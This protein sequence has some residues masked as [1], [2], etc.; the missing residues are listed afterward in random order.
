MDAESGKIDAA[1]LLALTLSAL[2]IIMS[3]DDAR[4]EA[5][6]VLAEASN[7]KRTKIND[8]AAHVLKGAIVRVLGDQCATT[9]QLL[10]GSTAKGTLTVSYKAA[11]K[12]TDAQLRE[13]EIAALATIQA[14]AA[15]AITQCTRSQAAE[16][17]GASVFD[18]VNSTSA[19]TAEDAE[20]VSIVQIDGCPPN[21]CKGV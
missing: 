4:R 14:N 15:V 16:R 8:T 2:I 21:C 17:F 12:P 6:R 9:T 7:N 10:F 1:M 20:Q 3:G 13:S 5:A 11:E 19:C 18:D